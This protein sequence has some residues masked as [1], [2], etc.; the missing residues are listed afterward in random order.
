MDRQIETDV[1]FG[2]GILL[3]SSYPLLTP[4][5][6]GSKYHRLLGFYHGVHKRLGSAYSTRLP[7][8][9]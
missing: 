4:Q 7:H 2:C 1:G 8:N 3:Y 9:L 5:S 6:L